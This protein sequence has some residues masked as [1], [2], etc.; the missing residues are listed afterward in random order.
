MHDE[1]DSKTRTY[2]IF[3]NAQ[4]KEW[5]SDSISYSQVV[6][7]A[8]PPPHK[9]TEMFTVQYSRGPNDNRQGTLVDGQSVEVKNGMAFDVTR[10]D[11]S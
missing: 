11:K 1:D 2:V 10:T 8:F 9:D 7:L 5:E 3:V 6:D 4:K